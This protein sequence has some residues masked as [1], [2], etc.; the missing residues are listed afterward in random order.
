MQ[1]NEKVLIVDD[2]SDFLD[3][4]QLTL[5][6]GGFTHVD[7]LNDSRKVLAFLR[8]TEIDII[9][10][11]LTMPYFPG[12]ELLKKI[13][14][15]FPHIYVIILSGV[16]DVEMVINCMRYGAK[17]YII[18]PID[19]ERLCTTI[20]GAA[21]ECRLRDEN[22]LLSKKCLMGTVDNSAAFGNIITSSPKMQNL[23]S[24]AEAIAVSPLS[25]LV[26]GETGTGKELI[27]KALHNLKHADAPFVAC[28][29]AG[30]DDIAFSDT[31]F[32]HIK[33]AFTGADIV[34]SGMIEK[35]QGG[36]LFLDEI[37]DLSPE[38]QVKLLRLLQEGEYIPLGADEPKKSSA[39][40][41]VATHR[42][43][44]NQP[45]FRKDL[46]FRLKAHCIQIPPLRDRLEDIPLLVH[47]FV[48]KYKPDLP[49]TERV[50]LSRKI[51]RFVAGQSLTG[52]I[53][54]L[55]GIVADLAFT[56]GIMP[57]GTTAED[58]VFKAGDRQLVLKF[59]DFPTMNEIKIEVIKNAV[60][61]CG[62][63]KT[64]AASLLGVS[65]QTIFSLYKDA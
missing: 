25:V 42:D 40:I 19:D 51:E 16:M 59:D 6:L 60:T 21:R 4:A 63:N 18:K 3:A 5:L 49:D 7:V 53:R 35:A 55:E 46:F 64:S 32:G 17:D 22:A 56:D 13:V 37:G 62:G 9:T 58:Q 28:N 11:D 61:Q 2:E 12:E 20:S 54:E 52:N 27:A 39:W 43:L 48:A 15:E 45:S 65:R 33:G 50:T 14:D 24:Y 23:F 29:V 1:Y 44:G 57:N 36:T 41:V 38:S 26:T 34:R 31:L 47:H 10:L 30:I 8:N